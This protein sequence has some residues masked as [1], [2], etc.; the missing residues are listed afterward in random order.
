MKSALRQHLRLKRI[1]IRHWIIHLS[2]RDQT[3]LYFEPVCSEFVL[4][5]LLIVP[6]QPTAILSASN[7][8]NS[9]HPL[10]LSIRCNYT[11]GI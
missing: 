5:L 3:K 9:H 4:N 10:R 11:M 6:H 8:R 7:L 2:S 1:I